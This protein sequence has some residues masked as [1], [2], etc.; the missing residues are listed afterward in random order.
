MPPKANALKQ[1][2]VGTQV[3]A[4]YTPQ[5]MGGYWTQSSRLPL[6]THW[7]IPRMLHD[8]RIQF[9]L[10]LIKGPL[11]SQLEWDIEG[12][13]GKVRDFVEKSL[14]RFWRFS[15]SKAYNAVEWGYSASE[16]MYDIDEGNISFH[17][18]KWLHPYDTR[19]VTKHGQKVGISVRRVPGRGNEKVYIGGAKC[20]WH[21]HQRE[22]HP[23]YGRSRLYGSFQPWNEFWTDGGAKDIRRLY[24][25]KYAFNG[26]VIYY[27]VGAPPTPEGGTPV[28]SNKEIARSIVEKRKTGGTV[29]FPNQRNPDTGEAEW[30]IEPAQAGPGSTDIL[31]YHSDLKMEMLEGLG[32]PP[33]IAHAAEVGSG[34]SGRSI[35]LVGFLNSLQ[36]LA[37][38]LIYDFNE[39][40]LKETVRLNFGD[41]ATRYEIVPRNLMDSFSEDN[42]NE[43]GDVSGAELKDQGAGTAKN[44]PDAVKP[45]NYE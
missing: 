5:A 40:C 1:Q 9:G 19:V 17:S 10:Y 42:M 34:W 13:T 16:C 20:L 6:F 37:N 12:A 30:R 2:L 8:Q 28:T 15:A 36:P 33:E 11:L 39:Q 14:T 7:W 29:T 18:I 43:E 23:W 32:V 25:H 44:A 45:K 27:P 21:I 4:D 22:Y 35:P 31:Q 24:Y 38:W 41:A 3:T 26:D